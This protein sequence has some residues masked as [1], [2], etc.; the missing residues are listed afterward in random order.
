MKRVYISSTVEDLREHRQAVS[1]F[2]HNCGYDVDAME[3]YP[4]R[5][6]RPKAAS[7]ADASNCDFYIG[8][9]AWRYGFVPGDD[10]PEGKSITE[11]EYIAAGQAKRPRFIFLLADHAAWPSLYRDAEQERDEGRRI[12]E[13]RNTLRTDTWAAFFTSPDDLAKKAISSLFQYEATRRTESLAAL[14]ELRSALDMGPSYLPN[15]RVKIE[16]LGSTEFVSLRLGPTPWWTTRLHLAAALAS[17]FTEIR[18]FVLF[19]EHGRFLL[20]ASPGEIRRAMMKAQPKLELAYLQSPIYALSRAS[21]LDEILS[22]YIMAVASVFNI[23][24]PD[25]KQVV[26]P[27][28]L[29]ELGIKTE[30]ETVEQVPGESR[31]ALNAE[32]VKSR[33]PFIVLIKDG[34][35]EGVIDRV[36][37]V[38][39]LARLALP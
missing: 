24:E 5:D 30:G 17:D 25:A 33:L 12:R 3:K 16:A 38:S 31:S 14:D 4:A 26:T 19:D 36:Q 37:L 39:R 22:G 32:I 34:G 18:Q 2:L 15:I 6:D 35:V 20:M 29:R 7:E 11:C 13:F 1:E 28:V 21:K 27:S 23:P 10:N 9:F 8:I